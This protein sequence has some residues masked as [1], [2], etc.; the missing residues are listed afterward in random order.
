MTIS[1]LCFKIPIDR[2]PN[3]GF[4]FFANDSSTRIDHVVSRGHEWC[5]DNSRHD[6]VGILKHKLEIVIVVANIIILQSKVVC[7][8][9]SNLA[10]V[11]YSWSNI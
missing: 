6:S 2:G 5:L 9:D 4:L 11:I 10:L 8:S 7:F 1:S 3:Q